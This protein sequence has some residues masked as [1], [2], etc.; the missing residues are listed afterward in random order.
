M[1]HGSRRLVR[2]LLPA[3]LVIIA[4]GAVAGCGRHEAL[5]RR[6]RAEQMAWGV[7]KLE[8]AVGQNPEL[9]TDAMRAE[10]EARHREIV[11]EFPPP[12]T[13]PSQTERETARISATSRFALA[14]L[15]AAMGEADRA[16]H[17]YSSVA[18]S[19]SFD[20]GLTIE[21]LSRLAR[22]RR[23]VGEWDKAVEVYRRIME[24]FRPETEDGGLPD[25]RVLTAP[26]Q[27]ADGYRARGESEKADEWYARARDYYRELIE[28]N[29]ASATARAALGQIAETWV[30]QERWGEAVEA[31]TELDRRYGDESSR[32]RIWLALAEIH[33]SR[34]GDE[35]TAGKYYARVVDE[36]GDEIPG[37]TA[38]IEIARY[39][40]EE[41]RYEKARE[42]LESV[43][44][45]FRDEERIAATASYLLALSYELDGE[46]NTAAARYQSLARDFPATMYGLRAPLHVAERYERIGEESGARSALSR[47]VEHYRMVV[48]DYAGT[49][50]EL[51][52]AGY[53]IDALIRLERWEDAAAELVSLADRH[54]EADAAP[55]MLLQAASIH[56]DELGNAA[57]ARALYGRVIES[58]PESE[59][60]ADARS[61][62]D[63]LE[64]SG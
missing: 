47:A 38:S 61:R 32:D 42:R 60:A 26:V 63:E 25:S 8:R 53:L 24:G 57:R 14:S 58:Y 39:D 56:H 18:D 62:L 50:A 21:A 16:V 7:E 34:L 9:A 55:A 31:Y 4:A 40:I 36:Y 17:W 15:A 12:A 51:A 54:P 45:A 33:G 10:L 6:Y 64:E 35:G 5:T 46:W 48:R 13:D 2:R 49:P 30:R 41:G 23:A 20:R 22:V 19:Y 1:R 43:L 29:P 11:R 28:E 52:A 3:A 44:N 37:A 59:R 27:V